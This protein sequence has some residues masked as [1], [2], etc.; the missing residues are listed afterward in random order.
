MKWNLLG[1]TKALSFGLL[2]LIWFVSFFCEPTTGYCDSVADTVKDV[3]EIAVT[4]AEKV[5]GVAKIDNKVVSVMMEKLDALAVGLGTTAKYLWKITVKQAYVTAATNVSY[6]IFLTFAMFG[7]VKMIKYACANKWF[8]GYN[9]EGAWIL[10]IIPGIA[11]GVLTVVC[12]VI[13]LPEAITCI[14]NPEYWAFQTVLQ[15]IR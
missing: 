9:N 13:A 3:K 2:L 12:I 1:K 8:E 10:A 15:G 6:C 4:V 7:Y 14:I 5:Q 11:L